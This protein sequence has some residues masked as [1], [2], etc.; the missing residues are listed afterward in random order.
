MTGVIAIPTSDLGVLHGLAH[1]EALD[2][3]GPGAYN[4]NTL[5]GLFLVAHFG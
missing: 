5:A 4:G 2:A 1:A 3:H